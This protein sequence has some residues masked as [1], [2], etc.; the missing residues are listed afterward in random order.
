[1]RIIII[2]IHGSVQ[3]MVQ[4]R[5]I[6]LRMNGEKVNAQNHVSYFP[7]DLKL[8][9]LCYIFLTEYVKL[10]DER[11]EERERGGGKEGEIMRERERRR[12][13]GLNK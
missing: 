9:L 6:S 2:I 8:Q 10:N 12:R 11:E 7:L 1:M 13:S 3:Q 5:T 4:Y